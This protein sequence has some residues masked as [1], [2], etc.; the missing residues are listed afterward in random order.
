MMIALFGLQRENGVEWVVYYASRTLTLPERSYSASEGERLTAVWAVSKY[1]PFSGNVVTNH[2]SLWWLFNIRDLSNRLARW[3]LKLK[4]SDIRILYRS[5]RRHVDADCIS[6]NQPFSIVGSPTAELPVAS[7]MM[8][9][10]KNVNLAEEQCKD[11]RLL[12]IIDYLMKMAT[13]P[14]RKPYAL[15]ECP[16]L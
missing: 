6:R 3:S 11:P 16:L 12:L 5:G 10:L 9:L 7:V 14:V 2:H 13:T 4:A 1:S 15:R 8:L